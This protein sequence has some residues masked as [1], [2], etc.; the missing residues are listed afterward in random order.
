MMMTRLV[1][2]IRH[3][4]SAS[5]NAADSKIEASTQLGFCVLPD[6]RRIEEWQHYRDSTTASTV[7]GI[8][9][10]AAIF[11]EQQGGKTSG[12]EPM[13]TLPNGTTVDAWAYFRENAA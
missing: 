2:R 3:R 11:C 5:S 8:A 1:C 4:C 10:P 12:P 6:G 9:N 13:C 7:A